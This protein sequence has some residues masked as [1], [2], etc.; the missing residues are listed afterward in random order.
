VHGFVD[1]HCH[2][3][4]AIDDGAPTP[5]EGLAMLRALGQAGF[6]FVMATPH[7]RPAMFANTKVELTSAFDAMAATIAER[8]LPQVGLSSEHFFDD[9]VYRR[10]MAGDGLPYPGGK[11]VLVEFPTEAFPL[12]VADRFFE[13]R[14]KQL[15]PVLAH[16][17]RYRPVWKDK[18]VLDPLLDGGAALLLDVA[19]LV[20]KYGRAAERAALDLLDA[21]YYDAACSD[22]HREK[23]VDDVVKGIARLEKVVGKE[24]ADYL[25]RE[26]PEAILAGTLDS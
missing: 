9:T 19:A 8:G 16:P 14:L 5:A 6:S 4:A 26:G 20:G 1:L 21:G 17:E 15:R 11:A 13:L 22:A 2:W 7:M 10:L 3:I 23:D 25:L 12:R 18:T 24:E